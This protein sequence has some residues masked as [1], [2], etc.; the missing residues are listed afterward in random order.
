MDDHEA[1]A[2]DIARARIG[3]GHRETGCDRGIDGVA[4]TPQHVG[5]DL[6]RSSLLRHHHAVFGD[7]GV[8]GIARRRRVEGAALL[9]GACGK[10]TRDNQYDASEYPEPFSCNQ[11]H[12][13][14]AVSMSQM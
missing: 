1:A 6:R 2:A 11:S 10:A 8:N 3:H 4:A 9:L 5:A 12:Q 13:K 14:A 7:N